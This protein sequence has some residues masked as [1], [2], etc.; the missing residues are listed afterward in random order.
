MK[1]S[2]GYAIKTIEEICNNF[3]GTQNGKLGSFWIEKRD[4]KKG[5]TN[6][7]L[8][9][10]EQNLALE[11]FSKA[12]NEELLN[13]I[14]KTLKNDFGSDNFKFTV[15]SIF[16]KRKIGEKNDK[17]FILNCCP[18]I[19]GENISDGYYIHHSI[20]KNKNYNNIEYYLS[21]VVSGIKY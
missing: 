18:V 21:I 15:F 9:F 10:E 3:I 7:E 16:I 8:C 14:T 1:D 13:K 11:H 19:I 12:I 2:F 6:Y 4:K 20:L 17:T 5:K